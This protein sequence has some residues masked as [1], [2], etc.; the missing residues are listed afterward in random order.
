MW[1]WRCGIVGSSTGETCYAPRTFTYSWMVGSWGTCVG[2]QQIR[3]VSCQNDLGQTVSNTRCTDT[4]PVLSQVCQMSSVTQIQ[5]SHYNSSPLDAANML[6]EFGIIMNYSDR[7]S[8]YRIDETMNRQEYLGILLKTMGLMTSSDYQCQNIFSDVSEQWVCRVAETALANG[9][10]SKQTNEQGQTL[11]R[12]TSTLSVYEILVLGLKS[13]C[14]GT[15]D[16]SVS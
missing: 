9:L 13:Q 15:E 12:G 16:H 14:I 4:M 10:I 11:F 6:A 3:T 2:S 5:S 1:T 7:P 8:Y